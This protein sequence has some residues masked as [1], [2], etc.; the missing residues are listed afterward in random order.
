[1]TGLLPPPS[2]ALVASLDLAHQ[3]VGDAYLARGWRELR[4]QLTTVENLLDVERDEQH[5]LWWFLPPILY[6]VFGTVDR[7]NGPT[8]ERLAAQSVV[9]VPPP[10]NHVADRIQ[11]ELSATGLVV[12]RRDRAFSGRLAA[13]LYGGF[14]W[15]EPYMRVCEAQDV[16]DRKCTVLFVTSGSVDVVQAL[17]DFKKCRRDS[18]GVPMQTDFPELG[19]PGLIR[20]FH[21]PARIENRRHIRAAELG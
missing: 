11:A 7:L 13:L 19:Y 17:L 5:P 3:Y 12:A 2:P 14:P 10:F 9:V 6:D 21:T 1:M 20:P 8:K 18:F 16:V 4:L 15:F